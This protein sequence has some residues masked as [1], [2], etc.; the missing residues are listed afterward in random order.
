MSNVRPSNH[1]AQVS[2]WGDCIVYTSRCGSRVAIFSTNGKLITEIKKEKGDCKPD[3]PSEFR[4]IKL[5]GS[6]NDYSAK[7]STDLN[8]PVPSSRRKDGK[9]TSKKD[10]VMDSKAKGKN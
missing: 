10:L 7:I 1:L 8:L 6:D 3:K 2:H 9:K 4:Q 5:F